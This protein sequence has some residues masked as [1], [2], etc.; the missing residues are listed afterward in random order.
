M[1]PIWLICLLVFAVTYLINIIYISIF[2]HRALAHDAIILRP[3][4]R[5]FVIR[6]GVWFTGIDP[7]AWAC[8]HRTHH[9]ESD[10]ENDPHSPLNFGLFG[11]FMG[12]LRSYEKNL[13]GLIH[14]RKK[15]AQ[16]VE[17]LKF[18]VSWLH[19][20]KLWHLPYLI[21]LGI[22][23]GIAYPFQNPWVAVAYFLGMMSHP[24]QGWM[25]NALGHAKGYRNY[26]LP[27]NSRNNTL[28]AWATLGEGFQ[29]NHHHHPGSPKFSV[30]FWEIDSGYWIC[31]LF[32]IL[33]LVKFRTPAHSLP[34]A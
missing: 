34:K 9:T 23:I 14:G 32:R 19:R 6:S 16:V 27:D 3:W 20:R 1:P 11:T 2:Y 5:S 12:Q 30:R 7:K 28:V 15:Y 13:V 29:N 26:D 31:V 10:T 21:H 25:V 24:L 17:D 22:G 18:P 4:L 8:M 33:G